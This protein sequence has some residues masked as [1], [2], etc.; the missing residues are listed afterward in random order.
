MIAASLILLVG[1]AAIALDLS[2]GFNERRQDQ[3]AADF[4][5]LAGGVY[6]VQ[7][8][9]V[10]AQQV[11]D[12]IELNLDTTY[13]L[14][15]WQALW[16]GCVDPA[17]ERNAGGFNFVAL[18][19]PYGWT[20][21]DPANWCVSLD[22]ALG[23]LRARV[24]DQ[25]IDTQFA[26]VIGSNT[27]VTH[28][29]AIAT[30]HTRAQG[31]IL[32]FGLPS[33]AGGGEH[34]CISNAPSGI[35]GNPCEGP[36]TGN[37]GV[38][39]ARLFGNT[40]L[41]TPT[42]CTASPLGQVL[43]INIAVGVD[44]LIVQDPDGLASNEVRDVCFNPFVDTM[45]TDTGFPNNGTEEGLVGPV[46]GGFTPRLEQG[47]NLTTIVNGERVDDTPAWSYLRPINDGTG[48]NTD[49]DYGG[50]VTAATADD[51]PASCDPATFVAGTNDFDG[52]GVPD[53][54][55]A[56]GTPDEGD[57][58]QHF[59]VC[60]RQYQGD[61]NF[62][63]DTSDPG[64]TAAFTV[65]MIDPSI[66]TNVARFAYVPQFWEATI[67]PGNVWSHIQRFRAV[68]LQSTGWRRGNSFVFHQPGESC[69]CSGAGY[70]LIQLSAFTFPDDALPPELRGDPLPG[71]GNAIVPFD[72]ELYR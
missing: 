65:V 33:G 72:T 57:S 13:T 8:G 42:N 44:H 22:P 6:A 38:L 41:G 15:Q 20:P 14:T 29:S 56:D 27:L 28:A 55:D 67:G 61:R 52:D 60:L 7:G 51:A 69:V 46:P 18:N 59:A 64:D 70:T 58:W 35:S 54:F 66:L 49:P 16:E 40:T 45:N 62:D 43:S 39:K 34:L 4:G 71:G 17:A 25:L 19:A 9:A 5:V 3:T 47:G 31:G 1:M 63:G 36:A 30:I 21:V 50:T 11:V 48:G 10:V 32:P 68:Y 2:A 53:D 23:L 26:G 37:F 12:V 24:P